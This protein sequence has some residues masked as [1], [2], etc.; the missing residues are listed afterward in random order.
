M[1][2]FLVEDLDLYRHKIVVIA[3]LAALSLSLAAPVHA[4]DAK[5]EPV[6]SRDSLLAE[7]RA[8][9]ARLD[10][11][12]R[13][14]AELRAGQ[15]D[16]TVVVDELAALRE[17]A[18]AAAAEVERADFTVAPSVTGAR[19]LNMLNPEI[20]VTGD[21]R[22]QGRSPGPQTDLFDMREFEFSFQAA[23]DPYAS[24][25]VF[26]TWEDDSLDL[27]EGYVYWSG[28]PGNLRVDVGRMRQQLGE[29]N[30][31]HLHALPQ[32]EYP[33]VIQS[34]F[35]E[36]GLIGD[37]ARVYWMAPFEGLGGAVHEIYGEVTV[38]GNE[39]LFDGGNRPSFLGHLNNFWQLGS[40]SFFQLGL[41][42][43]Y[44]QNPDEDLV[45]R[46]FGA[47]ARFTWR[48]PGRE[49]YRSFTLRGEV[50]GARQH[51]DGIGDTRWGW[52]LGAEYQLGR[53]WFAGAR[54]DRVEPLDGPTDSHD[55]QFVPS[56]SWYESEW[57]HLRAEWQH[58]S[59]AID[60][61]SRNAS[62]LFLV[63]VV[64]AVGPHKHESY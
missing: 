53:S 54:Y 27:E 12:E 2:G 3:I 32:T 28:L 30:R 13:V 17:A 1:R 35:G 50:Y 44:G 38:G 16:T 14:V 33:L 46:V 59:S 51:V 9:T 58:L 26:L 31:T 37:G 43:L 45:S 23:L 55:W 60:D 36:E 41:T 40:A 42:G 61:G 24:T 29:L 4:Q 7:L 52:Y 48:P 18:A 39:I 47:D 49:L 64:W 10:S 34:Y 57:V 8:L 5:K 25:K 21:M 11:L 56:L 63:Q 15:Q 22:L 19:N 62:D 6:I 20:S